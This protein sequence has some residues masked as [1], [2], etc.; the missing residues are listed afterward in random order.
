MSLEEVKRLYGRTDGGHF[1][2]LGCFL[3]LWLKIR[4]GGKMRGES[5]LKGGTKCRM[6]SGEVMDDVGCEGA[7]Q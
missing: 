6:Q 4:K 2:G 7:G 5:S 3:N 1:D